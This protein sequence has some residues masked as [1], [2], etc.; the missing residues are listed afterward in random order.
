MDA[1]G[2]GCG[3]KP[4][5]CG[6]GS[7]S[8]WNRAPVELEAEALPCK[9]RG[10]YASPRKIRIRVGEAF[11]ETPCQVD[12]YRQGT[13]WR[14]VSCERTDADEYEGAVLAEEEGSYDVEAVCRDLAGMQQHCP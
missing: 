9:T 2:V 13:Y 1:A 7:A 5:H 3:R 11:A 4:Q 12:L 8:G 6:R 10:Y 14:S